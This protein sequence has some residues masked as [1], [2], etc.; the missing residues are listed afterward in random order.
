MFTAMDPGVCQDCGDDAVHRVTCP[1]C[2]VKVC[3]FCWSHIHAWTANDVPELREKVQEAEAEWKASEKFWRR[4]ESIKRLQK[5]ARKLV[6]VD[7]ALPFVPQWLVVQKRE[8]YPPEVTPCDTLEEA[9]RVY[10]H[11]S[12]NWT[13]TFIC[14]VVKGPVT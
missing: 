4:S 12:P 13:E 14:L 11:I 3:P 6:G 7:H 1:K 10:D 2:E 5:R 8:T 9:E